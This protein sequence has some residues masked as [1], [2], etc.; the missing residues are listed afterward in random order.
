MVKPAARG[1]CLP[2]DP[3]TCQTRPKLAASLDEA[4]TDLLA[5]MTFPASYRIKLHS[6]NPIEH[7][8]DAGAI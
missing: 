1:D 7:L 8:S 2:D 5:Y 6:T 3:Q 4:D